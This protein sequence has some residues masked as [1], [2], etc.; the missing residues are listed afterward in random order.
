MRNSDSLGM[1]KKQEDADA[2]QILLKSARH[3]IEKNGV[4]GLRVVDVAAGAH[5]SITQI[6]RYFGSRNGLIAHALGDLYQEILDRGLESARELLGDAGP[7]TVDKVMRVFVPPRELSFYPFMAVRLQILAVSST[8]PEL[9]ERLS[10]ISR[11]QFLKWKAMLENVRQRLPEQTLM[12]DRAVTIDLLMMMPYYAR[13]LGEEGIAD[14]VYVDWV[15]KKLFP[16][17]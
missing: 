16:Q 10:D 8:V 1:K 7:L 9:E 14:D 17:S 3:E 5:C 13:L 15:R 4:L 12:D 2:F 11:A 6:Y